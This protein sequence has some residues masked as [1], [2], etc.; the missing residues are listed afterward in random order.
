MQKKVSYTWHFLCSSLTED[1][2]LSSKFLLIN[3]IDIK[4][5]CFLCVYLKVKL[6]LFRYRLHF[7]VPFSPV[8]FNKVKVLSKEVL[9][10]FGKIIV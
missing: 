7:S 3:L 5:I 4:I 8:R 10:Q 1:A 9:N 2:N 6:R